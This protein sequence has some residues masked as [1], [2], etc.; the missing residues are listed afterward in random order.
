MFQLYCS[1]VY[2]SLPGT[3]NHLS[4]DTHNVHYPCEFLF[5][6]HNSVVVWIW[7]QT[8]GRIG[9]EN[10]SSEETFCLNSLSRANVSKRQESTC[11][12]PLGESSSR[13]L[14]EHSDKLPHN[15]SFRLFPVYLQMEFKC[16]D[17]NLCLPLSSLTLSL[18]LDSKNYP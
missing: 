3:S 12:L 13:S 18:L 2:L 17:F 7:Y 8:L 1:K 16:E 14:S 4:L 15:Y 5:F 9:F 10:Q 11:F 6:P